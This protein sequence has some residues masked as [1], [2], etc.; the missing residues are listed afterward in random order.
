P[1]HVRQLARI[2]PVAQVLDE[3][4]TGGSTVAAPQVPCR[5]LA[6]REKQ[7][8]VHIREGKGGGTPIAGGEVGQ[9]LEGGE[10]KRVVHAR[11]CVEEGAAVVVQR[12]DE[13]RTG[14]RAIAPPKSEE[15]RRLVCEEVERPVHVR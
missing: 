12:L 8:P 15:A 9:R 10:E 13:R 1:V 14:A 5:R 6:R 7:R 4:G 2:G 3:D 11:L